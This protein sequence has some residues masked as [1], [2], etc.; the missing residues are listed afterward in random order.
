MTNEFGFDESSFQGV[1][2]SSHIRFR[3]SDSW[4]RRELGSFDLTSGGF[5]QVAKLPTLLFRDRSQQVL[6]LR[7]SFP[8][9]RHK[10]WRHRAIPVIQE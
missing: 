3:E 4:V 5:D 10:L 8:Y 9:E 2:H 7:N 6:N 1:G